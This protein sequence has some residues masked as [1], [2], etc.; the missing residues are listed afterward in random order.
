MTCIQPDTLGQKNQLPA[1]NMVINSLWEK[2]YGYESD[3]AVYLKNLIHLEKYSIEKIKT[4][5]STLESNQA[6]LLQTAQNVKYVVC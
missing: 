5:L 1:I 2:I 3:V 4:N 6:R